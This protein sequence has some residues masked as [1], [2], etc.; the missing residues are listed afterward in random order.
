MVFRLSPILWSHR[1]SRQGI[2]GQRHQLG[3][4]AKS[5]RSLGLSFDCSPLHLGLRALGQFWQGW[6]CRQTSSLTEDIIPCPQFSSIIL[7]CLLYGCQDGI[8][9]AH[10]GTQ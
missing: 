7:E 9:W 3:S 5:P 2:V 8:S 6:G 4:G 10:R 1:L